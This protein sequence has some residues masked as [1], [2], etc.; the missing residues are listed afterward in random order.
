MTGKQPEEAVERVN[1]QSIPVWLA[2]E[3]ALWRA[4]RVVLLIALIVST[5]LTWVDDTR[6][7]ARENT[8]R[9]A[10]WTRILDAVETNRKDIA[11]LMRRHGFVDYPYEFWHYSSGDA[12]E[13]V[14]LDT[15]RPAI[16]GAVQWDATTNQVTALPQPERPL[17]SFDE[18]RAEIDAAL[19]RRGTAGGIR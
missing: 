6:R 2:R 19:T 11:A 7:H 12:Y 10:T 14:L 9:A 8:E 16:Y 15:G 5:Y 3:F 1:G 4:T 13:Q 18:I 17:N